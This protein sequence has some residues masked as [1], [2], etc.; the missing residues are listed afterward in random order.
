MSFNYRVSNHD[1]SLS[2]GNQ[3]LALATKLGWQ[4]GIARANNC[5]GINYYDLSDY[6]LALD[7]YS[8]AISTYEA[9]DDQKMIARVLDNMSN[10]YADQGDYAKA[11]DCLHKALKI[12]EETGDKVSEK[13]NLNITANIY[14]DQSDYPQALECY[15]RAL[16]IS[17]ETGDK[18]GIFSNQEGIAS[19]YAAQ[20]NYT[21][22]LE[23]YNKD[24]KIAEETGNKRSIAAVNA[25]IGSVFAAQDNP[26][27]ALG[28]FFTALKIEKEI[29]QKKDVAIVSTDIGGCYIIL[30]NYPLAVAYEENALKIA[31]EIGDKNV[32]AQCLVSVSEAYLGI[33]KDPAALQKTKMHGEN[34][35]DWIYTP[36]AAIPNGKPALLRVATAQLQRGLAIAKEVHALDIMEACYEHL[37]EAGKL[38]G[39]YEQAL[40]YADSSRVIKDSV[41]SK[42]NNVKITNLETKRDLALKEKQIEL[43]QLDLAKKRNERFFYIAAIILL[44]TIALLFINRQYLKNRKVEAEKKNAE[45]ELRVSEMERDK[46]EARFRSAFEHSA[47]GMALVSPSW[48][49][50]KVNN[51]LCS[52]LGYQEEELLSLSFRS[53]THPEHLDAD[54]ENITQILEGTKDYYRTE[55]RYLHKNG[56]VIWVNLNSAIIRDSKSA[57]LYFVSQIENVTEKKESEKRFQALVEKSVVGVYILQNDKFIYVNPHMSEES[58]YTDEELTTMPLEKFVY[59]DD[60]TTVYR[61]IRARIKGEVDEVRYDVRAV[62]KDGGIIWVEMFGTV[63]EYHGAPAIIGTMVNITEQKRSQELIRKSQ[64]ELSAFFDNVEGPSCLV[65]ANKRYLI[66]NRSFIEEHKRLTG[67]DPMPGME[68]YEYFPP[69]IKAKRHSLL[70]EVLKGNKKAIEVDYIR[71]GRHI[72][73]R[74]TFNPVISD[75]NVIGI[76]TYSID[77]SEIKNAEREILRL[78]RL[79]Q[80]ISQINETMLKLENRDQIYAEACRIAVEVGKFQMAWIGIYD[81]KED[82]ITPIAWAGIE[83]DYFDILDVAGMKV[84][85]SDMLSA[86]AVRTKTHIYYND[87]ATDPEIPPHVKAEMVKR[88]YLSGLSLPIFVNSEVVAS[89][90]L[91]MSEPFFF[92]DEEVHLLREVT[93]N[94]TFALD[95]IRFRELHDKS[96]ANLRSMF[97]NTTV[98][99]LLLDTNFNVIALN[100]RMKD[101]YQDIGDVDID[102]GMNMKTV[103]LP[104]KRT[105]I[106][107]IY[108]DVVKNNRQAEY[109]SVYV[110]GNAKR[111]YSVTAVP[112]NDHGKVIG[113]CVSSIDTTKLKQ[114]ELEKEKFIADLIRRNKDLQEFAQIVSH[115]LRGPLATLL[116]LTD[117]IK[118]GVTEEEKDF[119]LQGVG[120]TSEKLDAVVIELNNILNVKQDSSESM[121]TVNLDRLWEEVKQKFTELIVKSSAGIFVDFSAISELSTIRSYIY[122]ILYNLVSNSL[123]YRNIERTPQI[124]IWTERRPGELLLVV[125]DNG[126]GIDMNKHKDDIFVLNRR[127][128]NTSDGKGLGLYVIKAQVDILQGTIEI[129]SEPGIGTTVKVMLPV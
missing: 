38:S 51:A 7:Y 67:K 9:I 52:M 20:N 116:G 110:K 2:Y 77:L 25:N 32:A 83:Y 6:A 13:N 128:H 41:Y 114:L 95:K 62:R 42:E 82:K 98:S 57:P 49:F 105:P 5:I 121:E 127:F 79:Y 50:L 86:R 102:E 90:V 22:A 85:R 12:S 88:G 54:Q 71:D 106:L 117:M 40:E 112:V 80:F 14:F 37:A 1:S 23:Y 33:A 10:V 123:K 27:K 17:E 109:E 118:N 96:E 76:S 100:Q 87:I 120:S 29:A 68:I 72:F 18:D 94:I 24:L 63:M 35:P 59:R 30:K 45:S 3:A 70:D 66:F 74:T 64:A 103:L 111:Y 48:M 129:D 31:L 15:F 21:K 89:L 119:V 65:D 19:V 26:A 44:I 93:E 16:R 28:Y 113:L 104:E 69:E 122:N 39:N 92:N 56:S 55:K 11:Q 8:K 126:M 108:E 4:P 84:S 124:R 91:V 60:M 73:Y 101:I 75:G 43:D 34:E 47:I 107:A 125:N 58:G 78:N 99:Y 36:V 81:K 61:N 97:N 115:N 46:S 53:I